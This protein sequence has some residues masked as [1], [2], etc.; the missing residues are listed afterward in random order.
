MELNFF[1]YLLVFLCSILGSM[2]LGGGSLLLLAL[3]LFTDLPQG[4]AQA[5]N[6]LLFLPTAAAATLL[7][8]KNGL[9]Q[10]NLLKQWL[11]LGLGAAVA[12]SLLQGFLPAELLRKIFGLYLLLSALRELWQL[13]QEKR[14]GT[15]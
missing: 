5:L 7:H 3:V 8:R 11:P 4:E 10:K 1:S 12:G 9:L 2:G 13:Y 6:L 14:R 15:A